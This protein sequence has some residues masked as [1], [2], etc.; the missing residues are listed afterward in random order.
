MA[1]TTPDWLTQRG[2]AMR[3]NYDQR[4]WMVLFAGEPQYLLLPIPAAGK[5]SC[6]VTQTINGKRL[7]SGE[8]YPSSDDALR[9]G[10]DNLRKVLGW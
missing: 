10:L 4:G 7:D 6:R 5:Y 3:Q 2:C 8:T 1:V 9:G